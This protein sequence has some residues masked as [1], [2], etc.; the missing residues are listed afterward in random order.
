MYISLYVALL[1]RMV[2]SVATVAAASILASATPVEAITENQMLFLEAWRAVDKAYVDKTFNGVNWFR[3]RETELKNGDLD[4]TDETYASIRAML[5]R[6]DDPFT[7]FLEPEKYS[8]VT[9]RT[10]KADVSGVGIEM[11]FGDDKSVVVVAPT[12]GGPSAEAGVAAKDRIVAVDGAPT[13]GKSLYEIADE[14]SGPQ[15]SKVTLTIDRDGKKRG[16]DVKTV[17]Y[18]H[19]TLPTKA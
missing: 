10:M 8:S 9:E 1:V 17:S 19:L 7:Q 4:D 2:V 15:G 3:L 11:G 13:A 18:T 16:I 6:L 12:P 5:K 14:L